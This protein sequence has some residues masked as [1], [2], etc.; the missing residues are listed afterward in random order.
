[1][2]PGRLIPFQRSGEPWRRDLYLLSQA[3]S[4]ELLPEVIDWP[5]DNP[6]S[7]L[8][9][10]DLKV[11]LTFTVLHFGTHEERA[12]TIFLVPVLRFVSTF[13]EG[14]RQFFITSSECFIPGE[15][16]EATLPAKELLAELGHVWSENY[17]LQELGRLLQKMHVHYIKQAVEFI[18]GNFELRL[19]IIGLGN[20]FL[21]LQYL[22]GVR[23]LP[24]PYFHLDKEFLEEETKALEAWKQEARER[25]RRRAA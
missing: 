12:N 15:H 10:A 23:D 25:K 1:M 18:R 22:K 14:E 7:P 24:S 4:I 19:D 20:Q 13:P 2:F 3:E 21:R 5:K 8:L 11:S 16:Y 6:L 9:G 17:P